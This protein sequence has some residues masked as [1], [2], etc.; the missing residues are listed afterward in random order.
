MTYEPVIDDGF[1]NTLRE[2]MKEKTKDLH[3]VAD[4]LF[5][6]KLLKKKMSLDVYKVYLAGL[7]YLYRALEEELDNNKDHVM[8][9]PIHF[10][11]ELHRCDALEIDLEYF[12]GKDWKAKIKCIPSIHNYVQHLHEIVEK[13]PE[14]LIPHAY[15]RYFGD[16]SGGQIIAKVI[17]RLY[18]LPADGSGVVFYNF[19]H[20][21]SIKNFK[22]LY[23]SRLNALEL[24]EQLKDD[25]VGEARMAFELNIKML[26]EIVNIA[27]T[28]NSGYLKGNNTPVIIKD[29]ETD[30]VAQ[31]GGMNLVVKSSLVVVTSVVL[32]TLLPWIYKK[33]SN[34]FK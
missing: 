1:G 33:I 28:I 17:T 29:A 18:E 24:S 3:S 7:Y 13:Q 10:Q 9:A 27:D 2:M 23:S 31:N 32:I 25:L 20:I 14:R 22:V 11:Q 6:E 4:T 16:L 19:N 8:I 21:A 12:Y 34:S 5:E 30:D 26:R 15:V